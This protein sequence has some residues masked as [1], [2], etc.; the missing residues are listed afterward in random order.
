MFARAHPNDV[1]HFL[2]CTAQAVSMLRQAH[3]WRTTLL[4][5]QAERERRETTANDDAAPAEPPVPQRTPPAAPNPQDIAQAERFAVV[6]R[7]DAILLRRGRQI[8]NAR[9]ASLSPGALRA[10]L[11]GTTPILCSL[12]KKSHQPAP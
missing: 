6:H 3:R 9:R 8:S 7:A 2:K 11:P 4:R 10:L 1:A 5:A 12:D